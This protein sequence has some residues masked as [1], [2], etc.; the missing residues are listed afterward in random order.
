MPYLDLPSSTSLCPDT[1]SPQDKEKMNIG[2]EDRWSEQDSVEEAHRRARI[3][4]SG[5][6]STKSPGPPFAPLVSDFGVGNTVTA[7]LV[8]EGQRATEQFVN[9][10]HGGAMM[11]KTMLERDAEERRQVRPTVVVARPS[12]S[13]LPHTTRWKKVRTG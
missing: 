3:A 4:G 12:S 10:A 8:R 2:S 13:A 7:D 9:G 6:R 11:R 5:D 1:F